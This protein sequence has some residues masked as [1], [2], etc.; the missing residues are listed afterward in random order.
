VIGQDLKRK[1]GSGRFICGN[2]IQGFLKSNTVKGG[3]PEVKQPGE[4][5]VNAFLS[6]GNF[7]IGVVFYPPEYADRIADRF[8]LHD[9]LNA[10]G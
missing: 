5:A 2:I 10:V 1:I 9:E 7:K 8:R 3:R 6:P 4:D